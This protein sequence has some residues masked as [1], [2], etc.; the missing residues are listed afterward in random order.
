MGAFRD[1]TSIDRI[2]CAV[3]IHGYKSRGI[4]SPVSPTT[5]FAFAFRVWY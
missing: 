5:E 1:K 2:L 4:A 3:F